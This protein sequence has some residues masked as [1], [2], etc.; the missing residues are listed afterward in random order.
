MRNPIA[1]TRN[2]K[3]DLLMGHTLPRLY[4]VAPIP[5]MLVTEKGK[6]RQ[7]PHTWESG[8]H[9]V[10]DLCLV[11]VVSSHPHH[12]PNSGVCFPSLSW[13]DRTLCRRISLL[14][15][16]AG[17]L[18]WQKAFNHLE[19]RRKRD[20]K[21]GPCHFCQLLGLAGGGRGGGHM[22]QNQGKR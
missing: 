18:W 22:M 19:W 5:V 6:W 7:A 21:S 14:W 11:C 9:F 8:S 20:G 4:L 3:S 15:M 1:L 10:Q 2:I 16:R 12:T 13:A 17:L